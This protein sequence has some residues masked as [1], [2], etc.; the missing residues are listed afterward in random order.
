MTNR[1]RAL[2]V[3]TFTLVAAIAGCGGGAGQTA[4]PS[5]TSD[6]SSPAPSA[7]PA[8]D[9]SEFDS[10][11][12]AAIDA[13]AGVRLAGLAPPDTATPTCQAIG[14]SGMPARYCTA[15]FPAADPVVTITAIAPGSMSATGLLMA[16]VAMPDGIEGTELPA[17]ALGDAANLARSWSERGCKAV[18]AVRDGTLIVSVQVRLTSGPAAS[19]CGLDAPNDYLEAVARTLLDHLG[20]YR[21]LGFP[22]DDPAARNRVARLITDG[23]LKPRERDLVTLPPEFASLSDTGEVVAS[24]D[25]DDWTIVFFEVRGMVDHYSGWVF[26]SNGEL[27]ADEDPLGGGSAIVKRIDDHWFHVVA[28]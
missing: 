1:R 20:A 10:R 28:S 22:V 11:F 23:T 7:T 2:R 5:T 26:R 24:R 3:G 16:A 4:Q 15:A 21:A 14:E 6:G 27:G 25:G 17:P 8:V 9:L 12:A 13:A 18:L 19:D